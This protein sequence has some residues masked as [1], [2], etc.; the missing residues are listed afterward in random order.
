MGGLTTSDEKTHIGFAAGAG[1][2]YALTD[3]GLGNEKYFGAV[4]AKANFSFGPRRPQLSL[5]VRPNFLPP[6]VYPQTP[7]RASWSAGLLV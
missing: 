2:E 6:S 5:L 4:N 3:V 1:A 7:P